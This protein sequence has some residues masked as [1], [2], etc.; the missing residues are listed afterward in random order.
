MDTVTLIWYLTT[1]TA[2]LGFFIVMAC[3]EN[4]CNRRSNAKPAE[5]RNATPSPCPS[6][7]HFAPPTYASVMKKFK[8]PKVF[9][10][11]VH[12]GNNSFFTNPVDIQ[13]Q[14]DAE[15]NEKNE[16]VVTVSR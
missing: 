8:D 15:S 7:K 14:H 5:R 6:Y 12:E 13:N 3:T 9:I 16:I 11:P 1:F 4:T 10:V 2:L